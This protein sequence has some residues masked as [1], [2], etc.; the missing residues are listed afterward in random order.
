MDT[1]NPCVIR[2]WWL[3]I[4]VLACWRALSHYAVLSTRAYC[5][6]RYVL[7]CSAHGRVQAVLL[8]LR[9]LDTVAIGAWFVPSPRGVRRRFKTKTKTKR[10]KKRGEKIQEKNRKTMKISSVPGSV[11]KKQFPRRQSRAESRLAESRLIG[12]R[13]AEGGRRRHQVFSKLVYTSLHLGP[14]TRS[15]RK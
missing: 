7:C 3:K 6:T 5:C 9:Y 13:S 8:C 10:G 11:R 2:T 14:N 15:A 1:K 4:L 12:Q